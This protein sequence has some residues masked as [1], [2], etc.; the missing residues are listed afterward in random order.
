MQWHFMRIVPVWT[1]PGQAWAGCQLLGA[2][3]LCWLSADGSG[4]AARLL[5]A[6][7]G[8]LTAEQGVPL[9]G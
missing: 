2:E 3:S 8:H 7:G 1:Q 5:P 4:A 9:A 6:G